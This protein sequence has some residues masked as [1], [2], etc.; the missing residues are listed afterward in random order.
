MARL[1]F[2]HILLLCLLASPLAIHAEVG[3]RTPEQLQKTASLIITGTVQ[4]VYEAIEVSD[5]F[6]YTT[7]VAEIS[8]ESTEKGAE[9]APLVYAR[10]WSRRWIAETPPPTTRYGHRG[11]PAKGDTVRVFLTRDGDGG[12]DVVD[13]N[14]FQAPD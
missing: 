5:G 11:V 7:R 12:L 8:V 2:T 10:Y 3:N 6:E 1:P 9:G 4:R 13:P 14:G